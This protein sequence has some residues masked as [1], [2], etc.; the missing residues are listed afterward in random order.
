M[1]LLVAPLYMLQVYD[2]IVPS[3]SIETLVYITFLALG[4]VL[5]LTVLEAVRAGY[6]SR[7]VANLEKR[8]AP[9]TFFA[10]MTGPRAGIGDVQPLRDL[11]QIRGFLGSRAFFVLFDLPFAPLFVGLLYFIHPMVFVATLAGGALMMVMAIANRIVSNRQAQSLNELQGGAMMLAQS[12]ARNFETVETL[13]MAKNAAEH[14]G[15]Q[16]AKSLSAANTLSTGNAIFGSLAHGIRIL[17][18][19][20]VYAIS[21]YLTLSGQMTAGMIF[22]AS[23]VAARALQPLDQMVANWKQIID[24]IA[25]SKRI[26][27][28][29]S[30]AEDAL[31]RM[32]L[33]PPKG[34]ISVEHLVYAL[35]GTKSE[36]LIKRLSFSVEAGETLAIIGPSQAGK[37]T[38]ARLLVGAISPHSGVVRIDGCEINHWD[39]DFLGKHTGYLPQQVE[40]LPGTVA[41]NI[42]RFER[43]AI[44]QAVLAAAEG[45]GAHELILRQVDGYETQIGP[46]GARLSGGEAQRIGLARAFYGAPKLIVLDEPDAHLDADGIAS[47]EAAMQRAKAGG[48]TI[49]LVTHRRGVASKADRVLVL[50]NGQIEKFGSA[51]DVL[52]L[53]AGPTAKSGPEHAVVSFTQS[54]SAK[55]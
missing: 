12:F 20:S 33:R 26:S 37:S 31:T 36:P 38:L 42:S 27:A 46:V 13:G 21:A 52:G 53:Q 35:P 45:A 1:L 19:I 9:Q 49:I 43:E 24:T 40:F 34:E 16:F 17:L 48:A 29:V 15:A 3:H 47:L 5:V 6:A 2:R 8:I 28:H 51:R 55:G 41:Q 7:I 10:A 39:R 50:S 54:L 32:A 23:M 22:A 4:A 25:A 18:Q 14:W 11:A 30:V 44:D